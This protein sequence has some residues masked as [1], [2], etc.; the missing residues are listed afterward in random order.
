[1]FVIHLR[2][3][4]ALVLH[5]AGDTVCLT[6]HPCGGLILGPFKELCKAM[7]GLLRGY[8]RLYSALCRAYTRLYKAYVRLH[9]AL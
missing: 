4:R 1:M 7:Y 3:A 8:I 9:R 6:P 5:L 2:V